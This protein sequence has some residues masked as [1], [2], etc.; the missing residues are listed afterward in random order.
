MGRPAKNPDAPPLKRIQ[1]DMAP[2]AVD[3]LQRLQERIEAASYGETVRRSL[4]LHETL[5]DLIGPD[6]RILV[7]RDG[8]LTPVTLVGM[9]A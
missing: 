2:A 6:G 5:L 4:W 8:V 1:M 3:R 9:D 7:E